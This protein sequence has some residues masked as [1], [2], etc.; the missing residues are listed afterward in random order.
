MIIETGTWRGG[1]AYYFASLFDMF[2]KGR[3]LT[4]DIEKYDVPRHDRITY[5]IGSSTSP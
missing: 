3:V 2:G 4:V 1:S 5:F